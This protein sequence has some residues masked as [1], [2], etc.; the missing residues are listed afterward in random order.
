MHALRT[1]AVNAS[2]LAFCSL[3]RT[4]STPVA[5][6]ASP[7]PNEAPSLVP[8]ARPISLSKC[9]RHAPI[10]A[11][12]SALSATHTR[13]AALEPIINAA[14][15]HGLVYPWRAFAAFAPEKVFS[16]MIEAVLGA[17]YIDRG[18]DLRA[19]DALL[20]RFG[21]TDWVETALKKEVQIRHPKEEVV[22]LAMNE[23]VT[24][25]VWIEHDDCI[26]GSSG[27]LVNAGK[28][29]LDLGNGRYQCKL[30]FGEREICS[31][32]GWNRI[33]VETAAAGRKLRILV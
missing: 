12:A 14:W 4:V 22:D 25:R 16:D 2:F 11:L 13:F 27:D 9:L 30:F 17:V 24:Y 10:L 18:G 1:T 7:D 8:T 26:A 31:A 28:E 21:I 32:R 23:K 29:K 20:R 15:S 33:D 5:E 19:C 3:S 6:I